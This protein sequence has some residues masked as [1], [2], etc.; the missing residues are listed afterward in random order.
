MHVLFIHRPLIL[1]LEFEAVLQRGVVGRRL[2]F[3]I[4][5][6]LDEKCRHLVLVLLCFPILKRLF[7][8]QWLYCLSH[9]CLLAT[10][11]SLLQFVDI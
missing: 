4:L 10:L 11:S 7:N 2:L 1:L 3:V 6:L 5:P 8:H 9:D